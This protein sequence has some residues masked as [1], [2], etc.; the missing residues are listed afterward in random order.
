MG[1]CWGARRMQQIRTPW[2]D[3]PHIRNA[4]EKVRL[5]AKCTFRVWGLLLGFCPQTLNV[6][7]PNRVPGI[8][9]IAKGAGGCLRS[10]VSFSL[11]LP[12]SG[13]AFCS[14]CFWFSSLGRPP[15]CGFFCSTG[16]I[17]E[18]L[19]FAHR[20]LLEVPQAHFSSHASPF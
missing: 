7:A 20:L 10:N 3:I 9:I 14:D 2:T 5:P 11:A 12:G 4:V 1:F 17:S 18:C 19:P 16:N 15:S 8:L 13:D 6:G